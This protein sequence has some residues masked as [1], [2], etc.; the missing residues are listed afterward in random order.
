VLGK[1]TGRQFFLSVLLIL[2]VEPLKA[3]GEEVHQQNALRLARELWEEK[4]WPA[5]ILE[6]RRIENLTDTAEAAQQLRKQAEAELAQISLPGSQL[7]WRSIGGMPVRFL[8]MFYR[9]TVRPALGDRC[10]MA[11][12]CSEYAFQ[13]ATERGWL[14][15]PMMADRLI[16]EASVIAS[17]ETRFE[18]ENGKIQYADPVSAHIGGRP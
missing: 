8:V 11:P 16:R 1:H 15:I 2:S 17:G 13:A 14:A 6:C 4:D 18:D 9:V 7:G 12:S 10:V 3:R 5:C